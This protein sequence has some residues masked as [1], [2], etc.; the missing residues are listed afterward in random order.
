MLAEDTTE[1]QTLKPAET[2]RQPQA[3]EGSRANTTGTQGPGP[4]H[5]GSVA[6]AF[7]FTDDQSVG[8]FNLSGSG[9]GGGGGAPPGGT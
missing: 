4:T 3:N 8:S 6:E 9:G 5:A 7:R 2:Q 1:T